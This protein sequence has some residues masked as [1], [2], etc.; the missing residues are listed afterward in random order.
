MIELNVPAKIIAYNSSDTSLFLAIIHFENE[1]QV[2]RE[3][4]GLML[5]LIMKS[6]MQS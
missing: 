2:F 4:S 1:V 6:G 5:P 3:F